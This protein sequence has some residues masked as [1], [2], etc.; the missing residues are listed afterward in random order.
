MG[1]GSRTS[2]GNVGLHC[3]GHMSPGSVAS[4][5][6]VSIPGAGSVAGP[7]GRCPGSGPGAGAGSDSNAGWGAVC[8]PDQAVSTCPAHGR[9]DKDKPIYTLV[10]G[11][12][13]AVTSGKEFLGWER[14]HQRG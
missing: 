5:W 4:P 1:L 3:A 9:E 7:T 10:K 12:V 2:G 8:G 13:F 11:V 14:L 6:R